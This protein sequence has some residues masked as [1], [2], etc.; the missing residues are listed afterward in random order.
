LAFDD[1]CKQAFIAA[2]AVDLLKAINIGNNQGAKQAIDGALW[3]FGSTEKRKRP[4]VQQPTGGSQQSS[5]AEDGGH[6][7]ISYCWAQKERAR[8]FANY[9]KSLGLNI[10]IDV[11]Q[12]EGSVL[13]AMADA[14]ENAS[15]VLIFLSSQ[16][17]E[18]QACR[19]EAEYTYKLKK[20]VL[21]IMAEDGYQPR[22][23]FL[24]FSF[25]S[26]HSFHFI[27]FFF[28]LLLFSF[29]FFSFFF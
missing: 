21:C 11:E 20:D 12:M 19:T 14:V 28:F 8:D 26:F 9:L 15:T 25:F 24:F 3:T 2:G 13:E 23:I 7:M 6:I 4:V 22:G 10:W 16:Y 29:F 1:T 18:S 27:F 17:K 5:G